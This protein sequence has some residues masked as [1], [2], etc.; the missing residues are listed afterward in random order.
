MFTYF[1]KIQAAVSKVLCLNSHN[2]STKVTDSLNGEVPDVEFWECL[3]LVPF[4][5]Y[6]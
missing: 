3:V 4:L 1:D 6:I 5:E 2:R